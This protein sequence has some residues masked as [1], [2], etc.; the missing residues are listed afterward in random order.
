MTA[1][2]ELEENIDL[3]ASYAENRQVAVIRKTDAASINSVDTVKN[4]RIA[5]EKGSAGDK[6]AVDTL[7]AANVNKVEAQVNALMEVKSLTSD[8]AIIDYTM[9]KSVVG[10]GDYKSLMIVDPEVVSFAREVFAVGVRTDSNLKAEIEN[11]FN[12]LY[13]SGEL[14]ILASKYGVILNEETFASLN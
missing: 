6:V 11:L 7:A 9:A 5:V 2:A 14:Q 1:T 13:K 4:A 8:V 10:K 12:E 3:T